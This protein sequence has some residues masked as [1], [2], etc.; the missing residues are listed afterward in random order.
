MEFLLF[1]KQ[2]TDFHKW[3]A[4]CERSNKTQKL[5]GKKTSGKKNKV[6]WMQPKV[7]FLA[8]DSVSH[9]SFRTSLTGIRNRT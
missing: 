2:L 1:W 3:F 9:G 5:S 6:V 4:L 8:Q 7:R